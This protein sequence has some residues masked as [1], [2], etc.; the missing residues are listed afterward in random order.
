MEF[1]HSCI[2][3]VQKRGERSC[4]TD[5]KG[6]ISHC[7]PTFLVV[8]KSPQS[9]KKQQQLLQ[10]INKVEGVWN[11]QQYILCCVRFEQNNDEKVTFDFRSLVVC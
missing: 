11:I 1:E 8:R 7:L 3:S 2:H 6:S 4:P 5:N 9:K 10:V